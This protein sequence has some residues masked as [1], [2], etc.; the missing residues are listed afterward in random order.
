MWVY[1][2]VYNNNI[3]NI[4]QCARYMRVLVSF[5]FTPVLYTRNHITIQNRHFK[6]CTKVKQVLVEQRT[7]QLY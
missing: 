3:T 6:E 7:K 1:E 4:V 2:G 5:T